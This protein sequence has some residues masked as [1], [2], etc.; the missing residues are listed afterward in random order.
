MHHL[1]HIKAVRN[2]PSFQCT[3]CERKFY[4]QDRAEDRCT[5]R[6]KP[7]E[8]VYRHKRKVALQ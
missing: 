4:N 6:L 8:V 3:V 2:E 7:V 5:G 1:I